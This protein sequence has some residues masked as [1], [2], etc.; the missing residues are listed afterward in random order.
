[1]GSR[2][3]S[4]VIIV[5]AQEILL[6]AQLCMDSM[7]DSLSGLVVMFVELF[8]LRQVTGQYT[9]SMSRVV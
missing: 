8:V 1:M 3:K 4:P 2:L 9:A 6:C 5:G 7:I